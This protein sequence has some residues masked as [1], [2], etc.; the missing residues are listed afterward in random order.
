MGAS[1]IFDQA[2]HNILENSDNSSFAENTII[3][4]RIIYSSLI[5]LN[6]TN[7]LIP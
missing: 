7:H 6:C 3:K 4:Y 1:D 2:T 5:L